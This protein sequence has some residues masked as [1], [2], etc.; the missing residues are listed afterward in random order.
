LTPFIRTLDQNLLAASAVQPKQ[1]PLRAPTPPPT[2]GWAVTPLIRYASLA[3]ATAVSRDDLPGTPTRS[4]LRVAAPSPGKNS[5]S[6]GRKP[7]LH[8]HPGSSSK[9]G[10]APGLLA[11]QPDVSYGPEP[12]FEHPATPGPSSSSSSSEDR[13]SEADVS[14]GVEHDF[15]EPEVELPLSPAQIVMR[16]EQAK[17]QIRERRFELFMELR[18]LGALESELDGFREQATRLG[19]SVDRHSADGVVEEGASPSH[20]LM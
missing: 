9:Q 8:W 10:S 11:V 16:T 2:A 19:S 17:T 20:H 14:Y 12:A 3:L 5:S 18:E 13:S 6:P 15:E 4:T 7:S 1:M